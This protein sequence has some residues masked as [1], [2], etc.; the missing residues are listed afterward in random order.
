MIAVAMVGYTVG[1]VL[2][3]AT[4]TE[5]GPSLYVPVPSSLRRFM[6]R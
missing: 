6:R 4:R 2:A 3:A 1:Y 5:N